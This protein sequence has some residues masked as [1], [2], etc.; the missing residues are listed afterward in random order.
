MRLN[1]KEEFELFKTNPQE[2]HEYIREL[3]ESLDLEGL[4]LAEV[5]VNEKISINSVETFSNPIIVIVEEVN[6][7]NKSLKVKDPLRIH[8]FSKITEYRIINGE[9]LNG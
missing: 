2:Y 6:L 8:S 9:I 4:L 7:K 5:V 1:K 3:R